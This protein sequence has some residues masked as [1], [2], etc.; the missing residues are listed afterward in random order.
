MEKIITTTTINPPTEA[1][2]KYASK[3]EWYLVIAGDLKTPHD[4]YRRLEKEFPNVL[5]LSPEDQ[6]K[7]YKKIS[8]IIGWN[9]IERRNIAFIESYNLGCQIMAT[10]DDDNIPYEFWGQNSLVN[11]EIL[12][13]LYEPELNVFDPLSITN[14]SDIW[15]RGYP[16]E[17]LPKRHFVEYRGKIKR[18]VLIQ[19]DLWDGDPDI[20][21]ICRMCFHPNVKFND[22]EPFG[23]NTLSPFNSQNV[24]IS[25]EVLPFY[26][27]LPFIGRMSDIWASYILE[28]LFPN[29]VA[30]SR[31]SVCQNRNIHDLTI[32]LSNEILGY[33]YTKEFVNDVKNYEKF[34]PSKTIEFYKIYKEQFK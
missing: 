19:A 30:Y 26:C 34:L 5:Y 13:D 15:H 24:F 8:E 6:E 27:S 1:I 29:S 33:K 3:K 23:S 20:D 32:D 11:K 10:I 2:L 12:I 25:R 18:K 28:F 14:N 22:L 17:Y 16:I 21:A 4:L 9:T 31:A 7:K